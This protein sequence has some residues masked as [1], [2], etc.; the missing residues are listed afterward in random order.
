MGKKQGKTGCAN[1]LCFYALNSV[2][3]ITHTDNY[4]NRS[5]I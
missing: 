3:N 5:A 4:Q 2:G 1:C